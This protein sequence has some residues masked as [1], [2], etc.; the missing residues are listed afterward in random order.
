MSVLKF[1]D[2][3]TNEWREITT[4]MGAPGKDGE[5]GKDGHTP[6][7]GVDYFDGQ[8]GAPGK[9]GEDYILTE[10]DKAAI[11]QDVLTALPVYNGEVI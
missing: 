5:P 4:I 11:V 3:I 8:P 10:E 6:V 2:P 1:K 9:D 7:K